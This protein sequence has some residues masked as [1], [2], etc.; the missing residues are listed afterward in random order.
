MNSQCWSYSEGAKEHKMLCLGTE[1]F[2]GA[3]IAILSVAQSSPHAFM[4][5]METQARTL[6]LQQQV[7]LSSLI[8]QGCKT[9]LSLQTQVN[10]KLFLYTVESP[11]RQRPPGLV[12]WLTPCTE[13]QGSGW[14]S[15]LPQPSFHSFRR[16]SCTLSLQLASHIQPCL[17]PCFRTSN[18]IPTFPSLDCDK[19]GS[20]LKKTIPKRELCIQCTKTNFY[21]KLGLLS[22]YTPDYS[23]R[24]I[25]KNE[26]VR[27]QN[28]FLVVHSSAETSNVD[29]V[30]T[31]EGERDFSTYRL[32]WPL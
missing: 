19:K 17:T 32:F 29:L 9:P 15:Y 26:L 30:P 18:F 10:S 24:D 20:K 23:A 2:Q 25:F 12:Q 11:H 3:G 31:I 13:E 22:N 8:H 27:K 7:L 14:L 4:P 5:A 6:K 16:L 28:C 1:F 21:Y